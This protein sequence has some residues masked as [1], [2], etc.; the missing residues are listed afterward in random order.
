MSEVQTELVKT[1][2]KV[3]LPPDMCL[4]SKDIFTEI[5]DTSSQTDLEPQINTC[6][7]IMLVYDVSLLDSMFRLENYWLPIISEINREVTSISLEID[8]NYFSR[9]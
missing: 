5:I 8:A 4:Y 9:K 7:L 2:K 6:D 1:L 3:V